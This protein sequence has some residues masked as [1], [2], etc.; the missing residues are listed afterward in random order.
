MTRKEW[1]SLTSFGVI[2]LIFCTS[3]VIGVGAAAAAPS[4]SIDPVATIGLNPTDTFS[5]TVNVDSDTNDLRA[6][7]VNLLYDS[8]ALQV[9]SITEDGLLGG[10][11][12][13]APGNGDD[14]AGTI[15]FGIASTA[16]TYSPQSGAFITIMFEVKAAAAA[17]TYNLDLTNVELLD[18]ANAAIMGVVVTD[19]TA[20][21]GAAPTSNPT[22]EVNPMV[23]S[24][25]PGDIFQV[26]VDVDSNSDDLRA[27]NMNLFY[28]SSALQVNSITEGS[29]LGGSTLTAPGSGD[30]GAG[31]I[32]YGI[33]STAGTYSPQAGT[34]I[35]IMFQ[36][37][38]AAA[39]GTY[40]LDLANVMFLDDINAPIMGVVVTD[41]TATVGAAPT[42]N[43]T[44]EVNP[45]VSS[46]E[47]GD[48]FQV[49]VD[50][51]SNSD[52]LRAV[53]M[54]LF[55]DSSALQVN[56]ITEGGLLGGSTLTAPGSGDNGAGMISYGI[57]S[58]AGT[59]SPQAGTFISIM[60]Q[61][62]DTA[63]AGTYNLDLAN[64]MFLDDINAPIM[65]VAV[66][67][68]TVDVTVEVIPDGIILMSGWN[69]ISV[70]YELDNSSVDNVL[71]DINYTALT[72]YN[73]EGNSSW[74]PVTTFDPL[75]GYWINIP[76]D[77]DD[78]IVLKEDLVPKVPA[79]PAMLQ[80]YAGWNSIG[81]TDS[82]DILS[83][84]IT[85]GSIDDY[86]DYIWGP[87]E[88][89][90]MSYEYVGHNGQTGVIENRH[91]G[92]DIF[93]MSPYNGYWVFVT[94]DCMLNAI[95]S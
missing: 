90:T 95:G 63:V 35:T 16:G 39:A 84:E 11:I 53:N 48:I 62:K 86:Y 2:L 23:S 34:F 32:S 41:G 40:N 51:D 31:M 8:S 21:V 37:K 69:F 87:W 68:G 29:L 15:S 58:T 7:K 49:M 13:A 52:D 26:M 47:P 85:L 28:D 43:P 50:V 24:G 71:A 77:L 44:I 6:A 46:G 93:D 59:Y 79:S 33:A 5:V 70:P 22:I 83:A 65:G 9:N 74:D 91:V 38:G 73:A 57:A 67:D 66:I 80:L 45:M 76:M 27:V 75:K 42:S 4:A 92:T 25:E 82:M 89:D 3:L 88:P 19:G 78:Q 61:I 1:R 81:Y 72:Y 20:T 10:S 17:G 60:F 30:D 64:V 94:Q 56:S 14:G 18:D 36:V 12:L 54:N 55:Y